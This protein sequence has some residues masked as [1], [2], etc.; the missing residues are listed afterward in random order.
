MNNTDYK[1]LFESFIDSII[2]G[3]PY[4]CDSLCELVSPISIEINSEGYSGA[5]VSL[6]EVQFGLKDHISICELYDTIKD[7]IVKNKVPTKIKEHP[8][9]NVEYTWSTSSGLSIEQHIEKIK[10]VTIYEPQDVLSHKHLI[11]KGACSFILYHEIGHILND[12]YLKDVLDKEHAADEFAFKAI[13]ND[14]TSPRDQDA[15][16]IGAL[17]ALFNILYSQK[18]EDIPNDIKHPHPLKRITAV[19][20]V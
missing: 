18:L 12:N 20:K 7:I 2:I 13:I 5:I 6:S 4:V 14:S 1:K 10:E 9:L 3:N 15:C 11:Y 19:L 17:L 8:A 16:V